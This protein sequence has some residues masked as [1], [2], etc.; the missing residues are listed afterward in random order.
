MGQNVTGT[1]NRNVSFTETATIGLATANLNEPMVT[2]FSY[3]PAGTATVQVDTIHAKTYTLAASAT[4][5]D[6]T[7]L[8]DPAGNSI[9][10][11]RVREFVVTNAD[12]VATHTVKVSS[13]AA[14]AVAWLPPAANAL[15]LQP[16]GAGSSP[17]RIDLSD[18]NG[19]GAGV[20]Y[21][22]D[23]THKTITFDPGAFTI[24][25]N[26]LIVGGSAA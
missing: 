4:T 20:G 25:I 2:S 19:T 11:A 12:T 24:A 5:I 3:T 18:P 15:V 16:Q 17:G 14:T 6:L 23:S 22:V 9:S 13:G 1:V 7:S 21:I 10:F 26:V 8:T